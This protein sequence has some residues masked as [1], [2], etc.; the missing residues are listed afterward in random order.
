MLNKSVISPNQLLAMIILFE[1]GT[2]LVIPIG[3][4]TNQGV[5]L[6]IWVALPGGLLIYLMFDYLL[7]QYP[8]M[9]PS[10]YMAVLLGRYLAWP[11]SLLYMLHF[12]YIASRNLRE[13]GDLLIASSYDQTPTVVMHL[14]MIIAAVYVLQKGVE[15]FFRLAQIYLIIMICAGGLGNL[16]I[17]FSGQIDPANLQPITG[18]GWRTVL[19]AAYP[20]IL[21][22]PFAE[23]A[24]FG[25][26]LPRLN[27]VR[28]ARKT[29][30]LALVLSAVG[31]SITHAVEMSVLGSDLYSRS[32]FPLFTT[33][34]LVEIAD[35]LQRLD[36]LVLL[37]LIIG[38]FFKMS[39]YIYSAMVTAA[40][41]FRIEDER[42]LAYAAG[43]T[44]LFMSILIAP[45]FLE[46]KEE[47]TTHLT[48]I[49]PGYSL[50]LPALLVLLHLI[51]K[52]FG[53]KHHSRT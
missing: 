30:I 14:A 37:T 6:S 48:L 27:H 49:F 17:L 3:G 34:G 39:M 53:G 25:T 50:Y 13:A 46:H 21:M 2:A 10:E 28:M 1:F 11:L 52:R 26:V 24:A 12:L 31:L 44:V 9:I 45:N 8:N 23:V 19:G 41:L 51:R 20:Y 40:Y 29:G 43:I 5:W 47:G 33:I 16:V 32:T 15:V 18:E 7:R 42:R 38:V 4:Q 36:A 35:F 22:F